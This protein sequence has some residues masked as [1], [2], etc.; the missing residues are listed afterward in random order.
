MCVRQSISFGWT[1]RSYVESY[2]VVFSLRFSTMIQQHCH[3]KGLYIPESK[4]GKYEIQVLIGDAT[5]T[6][7]RTANCKKG[8]ADKTL[9]GWTVHGERGESTLNY[10]TQ[11][12]SEDYEQL[13]RLDVLGVEDRKEF[14]Q[15]EVK[16]E[17]IENI[18]QKEDG[19]YRVKIPWIEDRAP[20]QTN[21]QQSRIRLNV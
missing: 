3:L 17:F 15:E 18:E 13:Y 8:L 11:T 6:E 19:R 4:D 10:F 16:K 1:I 5:F 9:F 14:D 12:T 2:L 21:E 7:I 20:H